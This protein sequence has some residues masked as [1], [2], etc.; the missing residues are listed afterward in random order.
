MYGTGISENLDFGSVKNLLEAAE[1]CGYGALKEA[2][3]PLLNDHVNKDN[4]C[5][6]MVNFKIGHC[7]VGYQFCKDFL[8]KNLSPYETIALGTGTERMAIT[9]R[10]ENFSLYSQTKLFLKGFGI[11]V[12]EGS[13]LDV[14][15]SVDNQV[16]AKQSFA[17]EMTTEVSVLFNNDVVV[18]DRR[19]FKIDIS[20]NGFIQPLTNSYG[21]PTVMD[22]NL[23]SYAMRQNNKVICEVL[24]LLQYQTTG[25]RVIRSLIL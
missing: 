21:R 4:V 20:G 6:E 17:P 3:L 2:V 10:Q 5:D 9:N 8:S 23:K 22:G 7:D 1:Y 24:L 18:Q 15:V 14:S 11:E 19:A 13:N 16:I 12:V 25:N